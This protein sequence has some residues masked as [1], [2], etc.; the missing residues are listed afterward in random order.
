M[1]KRLFDTWNAFSQMTLSILADGIRTGAWKI[2]YSARQSYK[3]HEGGGVETDMV[4]DPDIG[5]LVHDAKEELSKT[6][7]YKALC[8]A[9]DADPKVARHIG[10]PV[11]TIQGGG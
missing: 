2:R 3:F 7:Q 9:M 10:K 5:G 1:D 6:P 11:R 8:D 4:A